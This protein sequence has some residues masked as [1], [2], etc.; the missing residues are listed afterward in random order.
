VRPSSASTRRRLG[1]RV[2]R[3]LGQGARRAEH[4]AARTGCGI[5][6]GRRP[7]PR[8]RLPCRQ[9]DRQRAAGF[10]HRAATPTDWR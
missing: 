7:A 8:A 1:E 10:G 4:A 5:E 3:L 2:P 6:R 9:R